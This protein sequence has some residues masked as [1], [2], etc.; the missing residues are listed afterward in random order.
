MLKKITLFLSIALVAVSVS[1]TSVYAVNVVDNKRICDK[2]AGSSVCEDKKV[3]ENPIFGKNGVLTIIINLLTI[4]V[5]IAAVIAIILAGLKFVT[6]G[7]N[8]EDVK[9]ARERI[10]YAV[11]ALLVAALA[12]L[13]VRFIIKQLSI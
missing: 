11:V 10:V 6:S 8:P 4:I 5:G 2:A 13:F 7:S 9:N 1:T 3:T 12:Q